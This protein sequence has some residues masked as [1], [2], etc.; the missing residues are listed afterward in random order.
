LPSSL[1]SITAT[2]EITH[3]HIVICCKLF[4]KTVMLLFLRAAFANGRLENGEAIGQRE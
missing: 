3:G 1:A 4:K 2:L